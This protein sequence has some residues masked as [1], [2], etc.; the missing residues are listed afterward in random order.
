MSTEQVLLRLIDIPIVVVAEGAVTSFFMNFLYFFSILLRELFALDRLFKEKG[1]MHVSRWV[2]LRLEKR[3]EV[4][5]RTLYKLC[6][7]HLIETHFKKNLSEQGSNLEQ[8]VQVAAVGDLTLSIEVE[9][10]EF[11]VLPSP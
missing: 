5:E 10:L 3:V 1:I 11:S 9:F 7:G 8:R 6:S 4:P 2:A